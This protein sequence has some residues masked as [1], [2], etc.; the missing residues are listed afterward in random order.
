MD[1]PKQI[2]V[3][4]VSQQG[5][6]F[7]RPKLSVDTR[8]K[9]HASLNI[10]YKASYGCPETEVSNGVQGVPGSNPGVPTI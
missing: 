6:Y 3:A 4:I 7:R 1:H 10:W 2:E 8:G 5:I 9:K